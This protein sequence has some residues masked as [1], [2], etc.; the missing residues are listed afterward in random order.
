MRKRMDGTSKFKL[1]FSHVNIMHVRM[2]A[3][4]TENVIREYAIVIKDGK[5]RHVQKK[6]AQEI[7][8]EME[9]VSMVC[10]FATRISK[11]KRVANMK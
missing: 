2:T 1:N 11:E 8:Q 10:V 7:V 5:E 9:N 4:V 6:C 3:M